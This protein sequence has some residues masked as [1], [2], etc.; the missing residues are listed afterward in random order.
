MRQHHRLRV[1]LLQLHQASLGKHFVNDAATLPEPQ[2]AACL[3]HQVAAQVLVWPENDGL[4]ERNL[5][6]N[7]LRIARSADDIAQGFYF[8]AAIDVTDDNMVGTAL[9]KLLE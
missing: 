6:D 7:F 1:A 2:F 9:T 8:G 4:L 5:A 3:L